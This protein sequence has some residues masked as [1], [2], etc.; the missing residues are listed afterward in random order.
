MSRLEESLGFLSGLPSDSSLVVG[1]SGGMDSVVLLHAV[2][3]IL[4]EGKNLRA[5]HVN[6]GLQAEAAQWEKYCLDFCAE[7]SIPITV[8]PVNV[9]DSGASLENRA[10]IARY[11]AFTE[12]LQ[13][14]ESLL[15]AHHLDDQIETL[16]LRL[17][18]G[19]GLRGLSGIPARR[20]L[21][22]G[23]LL[24]PLLQCTRAELTDYARKY[25]LRYVEDAS[26]QN[27][28]F[29]RNYCR[30]EILP[31]IERRWPEYRRDWEKSR[32]LICESR[33]LLNDLASLDLDR[34]IGATDHIL[35]VDRL[36]QSSDSRRRNSLRHWIERSGA[37]P[38]DGRRLREIS[39]LLLAPDPGSEA[40]VEL[41]GR[42]IR[43]FGNELCLLPELE[44]V[45]SDFRR[46]WNPSREPILQLPGN[47]SLRAVSIP[48]EG[49]APGYYQIRYR[50]GG[51]SCR[52]ARRPAKTLKKILQ[53]DG[54][55]PWLR[56]RLPLLF[57]GETL[58][59]IP[60]IGIAGSA[61]ANP[62]YHIEWHDPYADI[63]STG[64]PVSD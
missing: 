52:L 33:E 39:A 55:A 14:G 26:N 10:R 29:D 34:C 27:I 49:L 40:T 59:A 2:S 21:G 17:L 62:G 37:G 63:E 4:P 18:R 54:V 16:L 57:D 23:A 36:L 22:Q 5:V 7:L 43:R 51:E 6:H 48:G 24:R 60:G 30:H 61:G 12:N 38:L 47:G 45:D 20:K 46:D 53:E 44:P 56:K 32:S 9:P 50:Q 41:E 1:L 64:R 35:Q 42:Q 13:A 28:D 58:A 19:A 11:Q 15:L 8:L 3:Q 25:D 31:L